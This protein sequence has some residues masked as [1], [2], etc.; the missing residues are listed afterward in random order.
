MAEFTLLPCFS[1]DP[2]T[3][4]MW[5]ELRTAIMNR[6]KLL[7][8]LGRLSYPGAGNLAYPTEITTSSAPGLIAQYRARI[9]ALAPYFYTPSSIADGTPVAYTSSTLY[10]AAFGDTSWQH[11]VYDLTPP[12]PPHRA[13]WNDMKSCLELLCWQQTNSTNW[14]NTTY[15][16]KTV[17]DSTSWDDVRSRAFS[18]LEVVAANAGGMLGRYGTGTSNPYGGSGVWRCYVRAA[19][20]ASCSLIIDLS[21]LT[22]LPSVVSGFL[23]FR[24]HSSASTYFTSPISIV[25]TYNAFNLGAFTL[26]NTFDDYLEVVSL[27]AGAGGTDLSGGPNV[28]AG[29]YVGALTEDP[30]SVE[31]P[32]PPVNNANSWD[33]VIGPDNTGTGRSWYWLKFDWN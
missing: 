12:C 28:M 19:A 2:I 24:H 17:T 29:D 23:Y 4:G 14:S 32:A 25:L 1:G 7:Q 15:Y 22:P 3:K 30:G 20:Q 9:D 31:W 8:A 21:A 33:G 11:G 16:T 6:G 27:G 5:D 10:Q 26:L 18:G 13:L